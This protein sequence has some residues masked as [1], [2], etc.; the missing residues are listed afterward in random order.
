MSFRASWV[1]D[2]EQVLGP[3]GLLGRMHRV[4]EIRV[5]K[6]QPVPC[7]VRVLMIINRQLK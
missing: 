1:L 2:L 5:E 7:L 6:Y 3:L 4:L